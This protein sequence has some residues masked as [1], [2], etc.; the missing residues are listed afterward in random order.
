MPNRCEISGLIFLLD[1]HLN[2]NEDFRLTETTKYSAE[3]VLIPSNIEVL[4]ANEVLSVIKKYFNAEI[5]ALAVA[6]SI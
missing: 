2:T 3:F 1:G 5:L 4:D 6:S